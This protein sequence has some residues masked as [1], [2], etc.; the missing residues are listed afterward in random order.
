MDRTRGNGFK[1]QEE[2]FRLNTRK[3]FFIQRMMR[4]WKRLPR[5]VM[6][7]PPLETFKNRSDGALS[8]L[9]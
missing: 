3:K 8:N 4:Y 7:D 9:I 6:L 1:S 2:R 5:E